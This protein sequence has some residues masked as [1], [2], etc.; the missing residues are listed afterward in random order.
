MNLR[1][2]GQIAAVRVY[3]F[4]NGMEKELEKLTFGEKLAKLR[5][6]SNYTQEQ[7]AEILGVSRQAVSKWES[8]VTYPETEKLL[9]IGELFDCSMDELLKD[10]P[11]KRDAPPAQDMPFL[12]RLRERK[13]EKTVFGMP[14]WH[15]GRNARG[16]VAV[17]FRARGVIAVGLRARGLVS[18]GMLSLGLISFG[19]LSVG[20]LAF[21]L[22]AVGGLAAGC[23]AAG[24][25][26]AGAV[27]LGVVSLGAAAVGDF[28]VGALALGKYFAMGDHAQ[29]MIALGETKA[30]GSVFQSLGELTAQERETVKGLLDS[31]VPACFS[32]AKAWI[33][34][35][36]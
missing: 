1:G 22:L 26:A 29:A 35:L 30:V 3:F 12:P 15:V 13:S 20:L 5:R 6:Q 33:M 17:G 8:G 16:F 32:W 28:S 9:R 34:L 36:I 21:G 18:V 19:M 4:Q 10:A 14:L 31:V 11:P 25:A 7:L 2:G 24:L 23:F 27:C